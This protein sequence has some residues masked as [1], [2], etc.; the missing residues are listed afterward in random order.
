MTVGF[1]LGISRSVQVAKN[2]IDL[3]Y[4]KSVSDLLELIQRP[5]QQGGRMPYL[6]GYLQNSLLVNYKGTTA[7]SG[8][9]AWRTIIPQITIEHKVR[10]GWM[11]HYAKWQEHGFMGMPGRHFVAGGVQAWSR[12]VASNIQTYGRYG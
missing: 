9:Y 3:V 5:W 6:T 8:A 12:I 7:I 11:A 10:A 4:Q 1:A 2:R